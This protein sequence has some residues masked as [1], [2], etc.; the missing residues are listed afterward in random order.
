MCV[1]GAPSFWVRLFYSFVYISVSN[2]KKRQIWNN[3]VCDLT[4]IILS[5]CEI[6]EQDENGHNLLYFWW[7]NKVRQ[8]WLDNEN[9]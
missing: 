7:S 1:R 3:D 9:I 4:E 2:S 6:D 5:N 8:V